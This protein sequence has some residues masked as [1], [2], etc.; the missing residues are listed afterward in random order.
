MQLGD[1]LY[2]KEIC[3]V[4]AIKL[5]LVIAIRMIFFS[6]PAP[7]SEGTVMTASHL[8]GASTPASLQL[9]PTNRRSYDQ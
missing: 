1:K 6:N 8:L 5:A 9:A 3:W 7:K 4:L 2:F